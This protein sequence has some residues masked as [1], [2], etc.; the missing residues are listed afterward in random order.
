MR[1]IKSFKYAFT[2]IFTVFKEEGNFKIDVLM[3]AL[4][5]VASI[6]FRASRVEVLVILALFS[7]CLGA[8]ILNTV[9]ENICDYMCQEQDERIKRIKDMSAGAVLI[10]DIAA[11]LIGL[12]IFIP[13]IMNLFS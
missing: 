1:L 3:M 4:V 7:L 13:K 11:A 2:G 6:I 10:I 5:T 12:C 8:E 9:A